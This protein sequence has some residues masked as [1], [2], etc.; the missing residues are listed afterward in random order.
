[1]GIMSVRQRRLSASVTLAAC[2]ILS[3]ATPSLAEGVRNSW[4]LT[5]GGTIAGQNAWL[6]SGRLGAVI[7]PRLTL[8]A[9]GRVARFSSFDDGA[10]PA[11]IDTGMFR[12]GPNIEIVNARRVEDDARLAGLRSVPITI[13]TGAFAEFY[14]VEW[15]RLRG[16]VRYGFSGH[17]GVV[18]D[19]GADAIWRPDT[20]WTF[21]AGPRLKLGD[22][23]FAERYF[24]VTPAQATASGL[25]AYRATGGMTGA[26]LAASGSHRFD[27]GWTITG[28]AAYER[29][30]G[31]VGDAPLVRLRGSRDQFTI[32]TSVTY[33]F[34]LGR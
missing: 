5:V 34:Q 2:A 30:V 1:M 6:G 16:A 14:P 31:S 23:R 3:G 13:E 25:P 10:S 11:L 15:L 21:A 18:A 17:H 4:T 26:G 27:N 8:L 19:F 22:D 7:S 9:P 29:L 28:F 24:S 20:R 33:S 12:F 32:G